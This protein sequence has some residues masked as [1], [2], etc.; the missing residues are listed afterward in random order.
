LRGFIEWLAQTSSTTPVPTPIEAAEKT[1]VLSPLLFEL[2]DA[3]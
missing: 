1:P 3:I 2:A